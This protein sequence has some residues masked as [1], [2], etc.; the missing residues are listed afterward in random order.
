MKGRNAAHNL[1]QLTNYICKELNERRLVVGVFLDLRKAFDV[2]P[3]NILLKKLAKMGISGMELQWFTNYLS[4]RNQITDINGCLSVELSIAIS[5]I[6][7]SI[8]GPILFLCF[9]ND[10]YHCTNLFTLLFA[11]DTA[12]LKSGANLQQLITDTNIELKKIARW[13][14]ANKMAVNVSK[15]KFMIFK[16][17][18]VKVP[19]TINNQIIFDDNDDDFPFDQSKLT[20]LERIYG[21]SPDI[22]NRTYKLLGLYLDEHLSFDHHCDVICSKLAKSNFIINRVKNFLQ[23]D[24]LRTIYFS[25]IHSHIMYCLPIYGCTAEK[26]L[27]KIKK[28]QKKAVRLI[29][30]SK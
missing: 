17:T 16:N 1:L 13:F 24:A 7:G 2:V 25:M 3:H 29:T 27:C 26:N 5:V 6:Q 30:K 23:K 20:P 28:A 11:D 21:A 9:I 14:R 4:N 10:L 8:L 15:T 18:G 19:D 22:S 12:G